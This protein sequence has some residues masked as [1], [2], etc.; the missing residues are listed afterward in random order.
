MDPFSNSGVYFS[1]FVGVA[2][3]RRV[4]K[5]LFLFVIKTADGICR[6]GRIYDDW[7]QGSADKNRLLLCRGDLFFWI[8]KHTSSYTFNFSDFSIACFDLIFP[9]NSLKKKCCGFISIMSTHE[10]IVFAVSVNIDKPLS[11]LA[12]FI[13]FYW[14][15]SHS[16][17][18]KGG[19]Q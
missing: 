10:T 3:I 18:Y 5:D 17:S 11:L 2:S 8:Y 13:K 12:K 7:I 4:T 9:Y 19:Y 14:H 16:N 15:M 6:H 1:L